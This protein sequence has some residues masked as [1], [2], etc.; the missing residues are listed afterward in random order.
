MVRIA[1]CCW[2]ALWAC[3]AAQ[4][5]S[6]ALK[7]P[8]GQIEVRLDSNARGAPTYAVSF[9]GQ[10][11]IAPSP[12][13][14]Q[15]DA[16][17]GGALS[18]NLQRVAANPGNADGTYTLVV[19]KTRTAHDRYSELTLV[20]EES[21][22]PG[23]K[24]ETIFRAYDDGVAFRYRIPPQGNLT[25]LTIRNELTRFDFASDFDCWALNLG[26]FGTSHEGEFDSVRASRIRPMNLIDLPLVCSTAQSQTTFA[27]AE[28]DLDNYSALYLSGRGDG[29]LGVEARLSP[30]R[31]D[32]SVAVRTQMTDKGVSSP[33][34]VIMLADNPGRLIESTIILN[35]NPAPPASADTSW[36]KPGKAAWDWWS[37][38]LAAGIAKP[39]MNDATMKY[40]IDFAAKQ[41]LQYMLIDDGWYLNSGGAGTVRP[42][43]DITRPIPEIDLPGL[44]KYAGDRKVGL[45][46]WV[47]WKPLNERMDEALAF[48]ER[49]GLKGIKV[50]FMDRDDQEM[51]E[52]YHRLIAK[53]AEHK[54]MLD[55]HG[56]YRPTGLVRTYPNFITQ[57]GV[58]GAEY[59]KWSRRVTATHNVTLAFTRM[60]LGPLDYTPGGFRNVTPQNFQIQFNGPNVMTT[61][62]QGLA[63]YVVYESPFAC[64][65]D[66]PDSYANQDGVDFLKLVPTTWDETR[67]LAGDIGQYIVI[68]RRHD[69]DWY[70]GAMTNEQ[71]RDIEVPLDFLGDGAFAATIWSDGA[72][73]SALK[74]ESRAVDRAGG[75]VRITLA[76]SG[77]AAVLIQPATKSA[78]GRK[79]N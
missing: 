17:G 7:S 27:I 64:V 18:E 40:Y 33:W 34:R 51:V 76:P 54:L 14:L 58:M 8:N 37:G 6:V 13:G 53:T 43:T 29:G 56:A 30:R 71:G 41:G 77:G 24:L 73:P 9:N 48:Y 66:S 15:L 5:E 46:V 38:P 3:S 59:N 55:L 35:L 47:H 10:A 60:L 28:A 79:G 74:K 23:R 44:V 75:A 16:A 11:V 42:G 31:D 36:I 62:G 25:A 49:T 65:S 26:R 20:Y 68:A 4:A 1:G 39:G 67:V 70:V 21:K 32:P 12:L 22:A 78:R 61:R 2:V 45:F 57:E 72:T 69:K 50:D 63:M 19:G 52:F